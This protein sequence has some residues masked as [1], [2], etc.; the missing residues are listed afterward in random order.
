MTDGM[1]N[2]IF[3]NKIGGAL[4]FAG[5]EDAGDTPYL[6]VPDNIDPA[7]AVVVSAMHVAGHV[8]KIAERDARIAELEAEVTMYEA[9]DYNRQMEQADE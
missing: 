5:S 2:L 4:M 7:D 1:F 6:R 8:A 9:E 3:I